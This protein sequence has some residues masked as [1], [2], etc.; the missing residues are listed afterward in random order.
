MSLDASERQ[1]REGEE[2]IAGWPSH[3]RSKMVTVLPD[4]EAQLALASLPPLWSHRV[5]VPFATWADRPEDAPSGSTPREPPKATSAANE[6]RKYLPYAHDFLDTF[7]ISCGGAV[8]YRSRRLEQWVNHSEVM[9]LDM[10][11]FTWS[12]TLKDPR[13]YA[14]VNFAHERGLTALA[15]WT[16]GNAGISLAMAARSLNHFL[17]RDHRIRVHALHNAEDKDFEEIK[18]QLELWECAT[19]SIK[20]DRDPILCPTEIE[21]YVREFSR[22]PHGD[23]YPLWDVSDGWEAVGLV[24]YRLLLAQVIRDLKPTHVV[25]PLG[26]GNLMLGIVLAVQ[27]CRAV[28]QDPV[29][30]VAAGP[31][32]NNVV[33]RISDIRDSASVGRRRMTAIMPKLAST[34]TPLLPCIETA[35]RDGRMRF[36]ETTARDQLAAATALLAKAKSR[37]I[38]AEPSAVAAFAALHATAQEVSSPTI[39]RFLVVNSGYG[40]CGPRERRFTERALRQ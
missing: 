40:V 27:D 19:L 9:V 6:F 1:C 24:M 31:D 25:A 15:L 32:G 14:I 13:S 11:G 38:L 22:L 39:G 12:R 7:G 37:P 36:H 29:V 18:R 4:W 30:V 5:P 33:T 20:R 8:C 34:Y 10:S 3:L 23:G 21:S 35:M 16:A 17:A 26:T 2:C 28:L